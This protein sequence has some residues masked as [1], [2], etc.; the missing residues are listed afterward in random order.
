M[1]ASVR[2]LSLKRSGTRYED[3]L[4]N[5]FNICVHGSEACNCPYQRFFSALATIS[6][7]T[8]VIVALPLTDSGSATQK[9]PLVPRVT[10]LF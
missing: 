6:I 3:Q 9:N 8:I 7:A 2:S 4:A 5:E 10:E 1:R